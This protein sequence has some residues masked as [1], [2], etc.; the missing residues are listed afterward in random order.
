MR[1]GGESGLG[2]DSDQNEIRDIGTGRTSHRI[3]ARYLKN[4]FE[5][6]VKIAIDIPAR[7]NLAMIDSLPSNH[8]N[9]NC[10]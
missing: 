7:K 2:G 5:K 9:A 6:D 3:A 1:H 10:S 4:Y 8:A